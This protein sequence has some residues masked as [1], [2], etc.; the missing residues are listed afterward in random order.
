MS[1]KDILLVCKR[2]LNILVS[3][4][5]KRILFCLK[6]VKGLIGSKFNKLKTL[7]KKNLVSKCSL[8]NQKETK[9][10]KSK[11]KMRYEDLSFIKANWDKC[12]NTSFF[13]ILWMI[14]EVSDKV[15]ADSLVQELL[16]QVKEFLLKKKGKKN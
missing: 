7:F 2:E 16:I 6:K 9:T 15:E 10:I 8:I 5:T 1:L 13:Q 12:R 11:S 14:L 4:K 3:K